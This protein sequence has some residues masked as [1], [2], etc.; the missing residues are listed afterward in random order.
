MTIF[1][2]VVLAIVEGITEFLPVSSTGHM[3]IASSLM[4]IEADD[5]TKAFTISVQFG[6]IL[7]VLAL[8]WKRFLRSVN[9]YVKLFVAFIPAVVV[10]VLLGDWIDSLLEN[11]VAVAIALILGGIVLVF[12]DRLFSAD[13]ADDITDPENIPYK[14]A[15]AIG[16]FQCIAVIPG[17]SRSA[18]TI[19][20]GLT[21]KLTR[22]AAAEFSF[23]LAIPTMAGAMF[24]KMVMDEIESG[25]NKGLHPYELLLNNHDN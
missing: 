25:A 14:N 22:K 8:Y 7:S 4:G 21:Q 17:V 15:F 9:F 3:I 24:K 16:V 20:G 13:K 5:F 2:A 6:A 10:G 18:A 11:V 1:E 19:I 12:I 23:F